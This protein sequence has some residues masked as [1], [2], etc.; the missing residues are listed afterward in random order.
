LNVHQFASIAD[1]KARIEAWRLD[2]NP[3]RP[4]G[5]LGHLT[6]TE[7]MM[8]RQVVTTAEAAPVLAIRALSAYTSHHPPQGPTSPALASVR[9]R[10]LT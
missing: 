8:E 3:R 7:F 6:P 1:A 2:Y 4:H 9:L 5:S 10:P